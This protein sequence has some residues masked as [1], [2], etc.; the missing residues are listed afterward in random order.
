[1]PRHIPPNDAPQRA[2]AN[3]SDANDRDS[4]NPPRST[5]SPQPGESAHPR[6]AIAAAQRA[7]P[8]LMHVHLH[9]KPELSSV[10]QVSHAESR[11]R[12]STGTTYKSQVQEPR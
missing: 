11:R 6:P 2:F 4:P 8:M 7:A 5:P 1:I 10:R 9:G 3:A 12:P